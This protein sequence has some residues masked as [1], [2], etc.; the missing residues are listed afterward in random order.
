MELPKRKRNRLIYYDYSKAGAYFITVC[1]EGRR[2]VLAYPVGAITDR[3]QT[4]FALT[5]YGVAVDR[6]IKQIP[7]NN[8][9]VDEYVIM[10][11]HVHLLIVLLPTENGRS[12]IAP[13]INNIVRHI[14]AYVSREIGHTVWQKSFHDH[15]IRNRRSYQKIREYIKNNPVTWENDCFYKYDYFIN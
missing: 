10:P 12:M 5:S 8:V 13:T 14:K 7:Y 1:T 3:P 2:C 6:A 4:E 9:R 11:N 15:V